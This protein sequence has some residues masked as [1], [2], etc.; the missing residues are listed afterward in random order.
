MDGFHVYMRLRE[1]NQKTAWLGW[2]DWYW[3]AYVGLW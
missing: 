1:G 3:L 2:R